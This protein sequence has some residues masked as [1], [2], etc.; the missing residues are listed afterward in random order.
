MALTDRICPCLVKGFKPRSVNPQLTWEQIFVSYNIFALIRSSLTQ[1]N[2]YLVRWSLTQRN[3]YLAVEFLKPDIH[4]HKGE[5]QGNEYHYLCRWQSHYM[6]PQCSRSQR[7]K[8]KK[9]NSPKLVKEM[10][11]HDNSRWG[12]KHYLLK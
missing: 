3:S 4:S 10:I 9:S 5:F 2:S 12:V 1:R 8:A 11:V 6:S 7:K